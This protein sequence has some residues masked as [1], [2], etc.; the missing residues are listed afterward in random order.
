MGVEKCVRNTGVSR[1]TVE[2]IIHTP[3]AIPYKSRSFAAT[4][5][6]QDVWTVRADAGTAFALPG[7][8]GSLVVNEDGTAAVGLVFAAGT[9][10]QYG[11]IIP[12][13]YLATLFGGLSF[14]R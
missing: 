1:G 12:A 3:T 13:D 4:V 11:W 5:W 7:D 6:V 9:G 8:S 10:G 2:A 14:V